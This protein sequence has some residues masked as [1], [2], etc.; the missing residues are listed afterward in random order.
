MK[1]LKTW[2]LVLLIIFYPVG[3]IYFI[4]WLLNRSKSSNKNLEVIKEMYSNVVATVYPNADGSSRQTY[5][6]HLKQGDDLFFKPTPTKEYPDSVGV[7]TKKGGQIGV[8]SY[9]TLNE[10]RGLYSHNKASVTV[11]EILHTERGL[12]VT[13]HIKIYK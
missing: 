13:M 12:G 1:K 2:Q 5:I 10:L 7:F 6:A 3:I 11:H 8:V 9:Q 4:F